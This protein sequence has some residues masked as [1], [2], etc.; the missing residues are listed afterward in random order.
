MLLT[1]PVAAAG[2]GFEG[3]VTGG[4]GW[5]DM[6]VSGKTGKKGKRADAGSGTA[7]VGR[8]GAV[9]KMPHGG[10]A[11]GY[12]RKGVRRGPFCNAVGKE[13]GGGGWVSLLGKAVKM[14]IW[15]MF[16]GV[17]AGPDVIQSPCLSVWR[18]VTRKYRVLH[19]SLLQ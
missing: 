11:G 7:V 12:I 1:V 18:V 8:I 3:A 13:G 5:V 14:P 16:F 2:A 19:P 9:G 17:G 6:S 4:V 10:C 15:P